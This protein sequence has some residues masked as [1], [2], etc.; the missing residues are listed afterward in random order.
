MLP[1]ILDEIYEWAST[2]MRVLIGVGIPMWYMIDG[3]SVVIAGH[4][5]R[6]SEGGIPRWSLDRIENKWI[7][8]IFL[9][10]RGKVADGAAPALV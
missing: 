5:L 9:G 3:K 6:I 1:F 10:K 8:F 4:A 7:L 2:W